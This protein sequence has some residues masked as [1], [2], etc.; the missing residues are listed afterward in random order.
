[1]FSNTFKAV[2]AHTGSPAAAQGAAIGFA[3]LSFCF[4]G[5]LVTKEQIPDYFIWIYWSL[6][7]SWTMRALAQNEFR[8][9]GP[10]GDHAHLDGP[11]GDYAY[12]VGPP[13]NEVL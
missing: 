4:S 8:T 3:A 10:D 1:A 2:T 5:F 13:N 11:D 12:L 9:D 7:F 6:P